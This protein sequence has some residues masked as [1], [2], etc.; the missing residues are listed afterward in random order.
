[1]LWVVTNTVII[2]S[3][4]PNCSS[5]CVSGNS[6][7]G[8]WSL[9]YKCQKM[10]KWQKNRIQQCWFFW[11]DY[12][13][14]VY[15][16]SSPAPTFFSEPGETLNNNTDLKSK[17]LSS[18]SMASG[19]WFAKSVSH[20]G[21]QTDSHSGFLATAPRGR[22]WRLLSEQERWDETDEITTE[23]TGAQTLYVLFLFL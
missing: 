7:W 15:F 6:S 11:L 22:G 18:W 16:L 12:S 23:E 13:A 3:N 8:T 5:I 14:V 2:H 19:G 10:H 17:W 1:M 20:I 21:K 4:L 9:V